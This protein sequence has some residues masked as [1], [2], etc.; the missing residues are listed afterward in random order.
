MPTHL[1]NLD[2]LIRRE[3]F[4]VNEKPQDPS[5]ITLTLRASDLEADSFL[6]KTLRKPDFQ[7]ETANWTPEKVADLIQSFAEGDL[8]PSVILWRAPDG[9]IF[10]IDGAHRLSALIGWVLDDYGDRQ[11]SQPFFGGFIPPEQVKAAERTRRQVNDRVGSYAELKAVAQVPESAKSPDRLRFAKNLGVHAVSLQWVPG[12]ASKAE[13]SYFKINQQATPIEAT[14][15]AM[16]QAR[17]KPNALATRALIRAGTGHKY[18]SKFSQEVQDE[19]E[20]IG[21][22]VYEALFRPAI[23]TPIKT[24]DLPVAGRGYSAES[25]KLIFDLV[26]YLNGVEEPGGKADQKGKLEDDQ[27]GQA[28][29]RFLKAVRRTSLRISGTDPGSL[30]LHPV[31]YFYGAT[32]RFLPTAFLATVAFVRELEAEHRLPQF[33]EAGARFE[34]FLLEYRHFPNLI[35]RNLGAAQ[36]GLQSTLTMYRTLLAS[37]TADKPNEEIVKELRTKPQL[38]FLQ[39][40]TDE[41]KKY[42]RNFSIP[43]KNAVFLQQ[44]LANELCCAICGA[45]MHYKSISVDHV[46]RIEDGGAGTADNAQL[47]HPYCNTGYKE[48]KAAQGRSSV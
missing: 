35:A 40:I 11:I 47:T 14:E 8:I 37:V 1:V 48:M 32:G 7:R 36:R 17:R 24:L 42:R 29:L 33:T 43:T 20:S 13:H 22:D 18:W 31:V 9:N 45:R 34:D 26:N 3:D 4:E 46:Q 15:L 6:Y 5:G 28:T 12:D 38:A 23:E 27:D 44:A 21:R 41:D 39:V 25:I 19:I 2:A 30:G 16:I 10:A